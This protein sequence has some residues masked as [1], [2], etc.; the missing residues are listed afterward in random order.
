MNHCVSPRN[1]C[2][3][4]LLCVCFFLLEV[5]LLCFFC[6]LEW[7]KRISYKNHNK[8]S[9]FQA[10]TICT[11]WG[12]HCYN[13]LETASTAL[14][15][16]NIFIHQTCCLCSELLSSVHAACLPQ[17]LLVFFAMLL[18]LHGPHVS[19]IELHLQWFVI[20]SSTPL[21]VLKLGQVSTLLYLSLERMTM[22]GKLTK[23]LKQYFYLGILKSQATNCWP[24]TSV[25]ALIWSYS[26]K[27][28]KIWWCGV[29]NYLCSF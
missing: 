11:S 4:L 23:D 28:L 20:M 22:P 2:S 18:K 17:I 24:A 15:S 5:H 3:L 8:H 19:E 9:H 26:C 10:M 29:R 1:S 21:L 16:T 27:A 6:H 7:H 12:I 13:N 14:L 25:W